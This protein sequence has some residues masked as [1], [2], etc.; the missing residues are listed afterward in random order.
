MIHQSQTLHKS[1]PLRQQGTGRKS[2]LLRGTPPSSPT[3]HR[4]ELRAAEERHRGQ[5]SPTPAPPR[6]HRSHRTAHRH[7]HGH[8]RL[9]VDGAGCHKIH[10]AA[11]GLP[12]GIGGQGHAAVRPGLQPDRQCPHAGSGGTR[13]RLRTDTLCR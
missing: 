6:N 11:R 9:M 2:D 4:R 3:H 8:H 13:P 12:A 7:P 1:L 10:D 5:P